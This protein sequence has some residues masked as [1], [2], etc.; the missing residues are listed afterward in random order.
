M[1]WPM[2]GRPE[3]RKVGKVWVVRWYNPVEKRVRVFRTRHERYADK[4]MEGI[5]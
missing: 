1:M 2:R 3:K 4:F 5:A